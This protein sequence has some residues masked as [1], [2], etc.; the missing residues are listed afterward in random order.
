MERRSARVRGEIWRNVFPDA[1][2]SSIVA[3]FG[4]ESG[5]LFF[6]NVDAPGYGYELAYTGC[7]STLRAP[8]FPVSLGP[9]GDI[10]DAPTDASPVDRLSEAI[11]DRPDSFDR[12]CCSA[13]VP[14]CY[15][16]IVLP[17]IFQYIVL[18]ASSA[19]RR[20]CPC[21]K[22]IDNDCIKVDKTLGGHVCGSIF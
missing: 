17:P 8:A 10:T 11:F 13:V 15:I 20:S 1:I 14:C 22:P 19:E 18:R 21:P 6:T 3:G 4:S 2:A 9:P 7:A 12:G 5:N 16:L